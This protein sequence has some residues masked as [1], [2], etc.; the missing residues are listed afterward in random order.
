MAMVDVSTGEVYFFLN[1]H[2]GTP[3]GVTDGTGKAVW[4]ALYKPFG[5]APVHPSSTI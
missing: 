2:L 3:Q 5:E 1:D 4:G